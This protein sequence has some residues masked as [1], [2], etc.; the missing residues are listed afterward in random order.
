MSSTLERIRKRRLY[1]KKKRTAYIEAGIAALL[2]L[3]FGWIMYNLLREFGKALLDNYGSGVNDPINSLIAIVC[4]GTSLF[5]GRIFWLL[6]RST[7]KAY[8]TV[9]QLLYVPPVTANTLPAEEVL[10][11]GSEEPTEE[12]GKVLLRGTDG[13]AG[14]G[15]QELLRGS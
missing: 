8:R 12:Q 10:V 1:L 4:F 14:A 11:R 3:L 13:S 6:V 9:K 5:F 15:E 7:R 2:A